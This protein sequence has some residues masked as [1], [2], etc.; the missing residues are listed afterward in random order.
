MPSPEAQLLADL[1]L[2][3]APLQDSTTQSQFA[4]IFPRG[5]RDSPGVPQLYRELQRLR[6][7][8]VDTVR[9]DIADEVKR[10]KPL[11]REYARE[12][13]RLDA[14]AAPGQDPVG[15]QME[16]ELSGALRKTPHTLAT[17]HASIQDACQSLQ[18]Q[19]AAME[20]ENANA[21]DEVRELVGALSDLRHGRFAHAVSANNVGAEV[22]A[23]L[24][25]LEAVC[26]GPT[27]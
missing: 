7:K 15:L 12:R 21:L 5:H 19:V 11:R 14:T 10:S 4:D 25:R 17:A 18:V 26:A 24:R 2:A 16:D 8:D 20:E 27:G 22:L 6:D 23:T 13:R 3:P 9:R 1:L